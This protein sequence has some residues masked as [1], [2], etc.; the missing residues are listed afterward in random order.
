MRILVTGAAGFIGAGRYPTLATEPEEEFGFR[1]D[2][3]AINFD[4][5]RH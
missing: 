4:P 3:S 1:H 5:R 2:G